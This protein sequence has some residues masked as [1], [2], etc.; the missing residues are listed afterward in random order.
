MKLLGI[1]AR[2]IE[3]LDWEIRWKPKFTKAGI[4]SFARSVF[5]LLFTTFQ[6]TCKSLQL[7]DRITMADYVLARE[8]SGYGTNQPWGRLC[9]WTRLLKKLEH[10]TRGFFLWA[11]LIFYNENQ[12]FAIQGKMTSNQIS[13][14]IHFTKITYENGILLE[15]NLWGNSA[16]QRWNSPWF[17]GYR[18]QSNWWIK[19][20]YNVKFRGIRL[21][22]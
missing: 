9:A 18:S 19:N 21:V 22:F 17:G 1:W 16:R 2:K 5:L 13:G 12:L 8:E 6:K 20:I 10:T 3:S 7:I 4:A 11:I 15:Y 14:I